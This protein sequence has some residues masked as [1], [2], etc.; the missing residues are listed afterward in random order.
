MILY[1]TS[2]PRLLALLIGL[3]LGSAAWAFG[4]TPPQAGF[5][6]DS[7]RLSN[8]TLGQ[9]ELF[10]TDASVGATT[11][12]FRVHLPNDFANPIATA[13]LA[14][15]GQGLQIDY[16]PAN[17]STCLNYEVSQIVS[18]G[19]G[20]DTITTGFQAGCSCFSQP[21]SYQVQ[22]V[23][24]GN[25]LVDIMAVSND[26]SQ[27]KEVLFGNCP[28]QSS[29]CQAQLP[30]PGSYTFCAQ[31]SSGS[32]SQ[33]GINICE[34]VNF[35][36]S[37]PPNASFS[38]TTTGALVDFTDQSTGWA[39]SS[40][41]WDFGDGTTSTAQN[42]SHQY[43]AAGTYT[44]CLVTTDQCGTD[45]S[46]QSVAITCPA[47]Q[48][49]FS[50]VQTGLST[51]FS[52]LSSASSGVSFLWDFGDGTTSTAVNPNHVYP[53]PGNY[54]VCLTTTDVCGTDSSCQVLSVACLPTTANFSFSINNFTLSLTDLSSTNGNTGYFWT[55]GDGASSS[56]PNPTHNYFANGTYTV[57]QIVTDPCGSDTF[58]QT[59]TI[60]CPVPVAAFSSNANQLAVQF[61]DQSQNANNSWSW[62]F[63]DGNASTQQNPQH[64]YATPGTYTVCLT[65]ANACGTSTDCQ[66]V[67]VSCPAPSVAF[68]SSFTGLTA[69]FTDQTVLN[70]NP[71]SY[72]WAFG[73]GN[74]SNQQNPQHTYANPGN[75][76]VCLTVQEDCGTDID[77]QF[78]DVVVGR[79]EAII[80]G[81]TLAPNPARESV[82][83]AWEAGLSE[84][85]W[86]RIWDASG[87]LVI[88]KAVGTGLG[89]MV[90]DVQNLKSGIYRVGAIIGDRQASL[91]LSI[92]R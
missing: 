50:S 4:Q 45:S 38:T 74:T 25:G 41:L 7:V 85:G 2:A 36:C 31:F 18:N 66:S 43:A 23:D 8:Q 37:G 6:I 81:F 83:I 67:T 72:T 28:V 13:S 26:D 49:S 75:F 65:T 3:L 70:G 20:A 53:G 34:T 54:T 22:V 27:I 5:V 80:P 14:T 59:V 33:A 84:E 69:Q 68:T 35:T 79:D 19:G 48:A 1:R 12:D 46:C 42:P 17:P 24:L 52:N 16:S 89:E 30:G 91:P 86:I 71:I 39:I 47:P 56:T 90:F 32:C 82:Q 77:C 29:S 76:Q 10:L 51:A 60:N 87:K 61:T 15:P 92:L 58:C 64:T 44:V 78:L 62:Q 73:D 63:G 21:L 55:F 40:W 11:I 88:E 9:F 57:C